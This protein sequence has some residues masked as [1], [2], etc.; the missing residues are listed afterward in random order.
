MSHIE[1]MLLCLQ[2][3]VIPVSISAHAHFRIIKQRIVI[4][5]AT[6]IWS[7]GICTD[8]LSD[9]EGSANTFGVRKECD[10]RV[11]MKI[12]FRFRENQIEGPTVVGFPVHSD[13]RYNHVVGVGLCGDTKDVIE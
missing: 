12:Y 2:S 11:Q 1:T 9:A 7:E 3:G 4:F 5:R 13:L 8:I 10:S 6:N